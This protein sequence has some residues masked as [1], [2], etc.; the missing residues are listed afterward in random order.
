MLTGSIDVER[1]CV[2]PPAHQVSGHPQWLGAEIGGHPSTRVTQVGRSPVHQ[3]GAI[4]R[5][6]NLRKHRIVG[7]R[8][9]G[10]N[11]GTVQ[12]LDPLRAGIEGDACSLADQLTNSRRRLLPC[13]APILGPAGAICTLCWH[14][15]AGFTLHG[16]CVREITVWVCWMSRPC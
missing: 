10:R 9:I 1:Y 2:Q 8:R 16:R 13:H 12:F 14:Y 7:D 5:L 11:R 4:G 3:V 15:C 6:D